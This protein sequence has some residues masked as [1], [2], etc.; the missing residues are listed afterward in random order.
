MG[1]N[2]GS[3]PESAGPANLCR[4]LLRK[5]EYCAM[6][7]PTGRIETGLRG[8]RGSEEKEENARLKHFALDLRQPRIFLFFPPQPIEKS[9]F[10]RIKPSKSKPFCL[11]LFGFAWIGLDGF[12]AGPS[13]EGGRGHQR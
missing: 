10:G 13:V 12:D 8:T 2:E 6:H 9:G 4:A 5:S 1:P 7:F 11:D 3:A